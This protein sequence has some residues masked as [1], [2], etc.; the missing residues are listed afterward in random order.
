MSTTVAAPFEQLAAGLRGA[1]ITP[2]HPEYEAARRVYNG[3]IDKR[4]AAIVR[5]AD[6]ADVIGAV[7]FARAHDL[8]LAIRGGGHNGPGLGTCEGGLVL[9]LGA[10]NGVRVD[11]ASRTVRVEGGATLA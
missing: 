8:L 3:M 6:V 1:L 7:R 5:A 9:D 10:L 2:E 4:P 11:P